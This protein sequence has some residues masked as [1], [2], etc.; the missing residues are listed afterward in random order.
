MKNKKI[1]GVIPAR[2][3]STR[4]PGKPLADIWGKPMI[5][6][7]YEQVATSKLCDELVVATDN[8]LIFET[9]TAF[10]GKVVMTSSDH[11]SGTD[12]CAE[13]LEKITVDADVVI[14]IQGDEP[15]INAEDLA[16]LIDS[17]NDASVDISTLA[18]PIKD[19]DTLFDENKVKVVTSA[20][21]Q[22]LY[23]SRATIPFQ[24]GVNREKWLE[25]M[26][27]KKHLGVYA[28]KTEVL[29][30]VAGLPLGKLEQLEH[31][32]QLRWLEKGYTISVQLTE[33]E[34]IAVDTPEDL[35]AILKNEVLKTSHI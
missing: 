30:T 31:L 25:N 33:N 14:N 21:N 35:Q 19:V 10:G 4:F 17:F 7:V 20:Q 29:K 2:F 8:D 11:Q 23:F 18:T 5:Q 32:E 22:A 12:R 27:Y 13:V 9:V 28:F 24:R 3:A 26:T 16:L 34:A 6:R 15:F 1:L